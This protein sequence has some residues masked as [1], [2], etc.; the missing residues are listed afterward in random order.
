MALKN[1]KTGQDISEE[2][3]EQNEDSETLVQKD[4]L[5]KLM[6]AL[7]TSSEESRKFESD[8]EK[9]LQNITKLL[10]NQAQDKQAAAETLEVMKKEISAEQANIFDA[11]LKKIVDQRVKDA[12]RTLEGNLPGRTA[13]N[14]DRHGRADKITIAL[15]ICLNAFILLVFSALLVLIRSG[16]L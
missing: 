16:L 13:V 6:E 9:S 7:R 15:L 12:Q 8:T 14:G 10:Q 2:I 11:Y 3:P 4:L 1:L 5:L